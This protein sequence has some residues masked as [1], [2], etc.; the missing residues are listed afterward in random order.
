MHIVELSAGVVKGN[1]KVTNVSLTQNQCLQC[2]TLPLSHAEIL[3]LRDAT[4]LNN[5]GMI[6]FVVDH[7]QTE[8]NLLIYPKR[9]NQR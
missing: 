4:V 5:D 3:R 6:K 2:V 7:Y 9:F 1:I 8:R